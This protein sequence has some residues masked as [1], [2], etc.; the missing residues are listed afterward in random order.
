MQ[1]SELNAQHGRLLPCA[2]KAASQDEG[3]CALGKKLDAHP[4]FAGDLLPVALKQIALEI[5]ELA[6][7]RAYQIISSA[8]SKSLQVV[9]ADHSAIKHPHSTLHPVFVLDLGNDLL[10]GRHVGGVSVENLV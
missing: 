8:L 9:L 3:L 4:G 6:A 2:L 10:Q 1:A 5:G 7:R